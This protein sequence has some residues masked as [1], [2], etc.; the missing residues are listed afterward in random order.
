MSAEIEAWPRPHRLTVDDYRRMAEI[1]LFAS[2]DRVEL[3]E[4]A[5]V[6]M[7]PIGSLHAATVTALAER[8][9]RSVDASAHV[10][11]QQPLVL[12]P[13]SEP[14]PDLAVV[15][16]RPERYKI[17][18]PGP[19]DVLLLVEVADAT[20]QFDLE[21]KA[22]LYAA[23]GIAEYWVVDLVHRSLRVLGGRQGD[24]YSRREALASGRASAGRLHF[25]VEV[26][27]LF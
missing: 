26:A 13:D 5:I 8:L 6:D 10:R 12:A 16:G 14:Q 4:G 25:S 9:T 22:R 27:E 7:A 17:E 18:H 1:R 20:L 15:N 19:K 23:H 24:T 2:D 3:I 11:V 21:T